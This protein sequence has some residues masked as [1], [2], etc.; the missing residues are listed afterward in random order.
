[1]RSRVI[2]AIDP[3]FDRLGM[4]VLEESDAKLAL[5]YSECFKTSPKDS[6]ML[7]LEYIG[8]KVESVIKKWKPAELAIETLFFNQNVTSAIGVAEAR[9]VVLYEA[10]LAGLSMFEYGPQTVKVAVTGYGKADKKQVEDMV[11]RTLSIATKQGKTSDDEMDAIA[12]GITH[13]VSSRGV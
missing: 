1:M 3:G 4:A 9:G 8:K 11:K 13:L 10:S 12:L 6:K 7:R 5:L 2:L